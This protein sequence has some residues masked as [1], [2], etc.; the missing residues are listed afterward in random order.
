MPESTRGR[1]AEPGRGVVGLAVPLMAGLIGALLGAGV[2]AAVLLDGEPN[3][4]RANALDAPGAERV[5]PTFDLEGIEDLDR[6]A[7]VAESVLPTVVRLG[8]AGAAVRPRAYGSGVVIRSDGYVVTNEHVVDGLDDFEVQLADG[9]ELRGEVVGTDRRTDL[10][11]VKVDVDGL[12]AI[13]VGETAD[14]RVGMPAIAVGSPFG[15]AGTVTSGVVSGLNRPIEVTTEEGRQRY[16]NVIQTDAAINPGNSGGPLV[17]ADGRLLGINSAILTRGQT[18]ANAGVG[19]AIPAETVVA[20]VERLIA[21]GEITHAFLGVQG[22]D[23]RGEAAERAGVAEGAY[24]EEVM[25]GTPADAAGLAVG[26]VIVGFGGAEITSMTE[27][28]GVILR[29]DVGDQVTV[30]YWRDGEERRS[31]ATLAERPD[32]P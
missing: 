8:P 16:D 6:V 11:V 18:P 27:L 24:V 3:P 20:V 9:R 29:F 4:D 19:F 22:S 26:D 23:V 12:T 13:E 32:D 2:V 10:A 30:T 15:L 7:A 31:Q 14:L 1:E 28:I 17:G 25:E 21:H 5:A